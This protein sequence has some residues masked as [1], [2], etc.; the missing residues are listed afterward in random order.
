MKR[1]PHKGWLRSAGCNTNANSSTNMLQPRVSAM[2]R[3]F[4]CACPSSSRCVT[5]LNARRHNKWFSQGGLTMCECQC[6]R[7]ST[8]QYEG[9]L[10]VWRALRGLSTGQLNELG[11]CRCRSFVRSASMPNPDASMHQIGKSMRTMTWSSSRG[12]DAP[13]A[14][15]N[16]LGG[17]LS[18]TMACCQCG[19]L[20]DVPRWNNGAHL[21][22]ARV[23]PSCSVHQSQTLM[24]HR[25]KLLR[26]GYGRMVFFKG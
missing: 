17:P 5:L 6:A 24:R 7:W 3:Q 21:P 23:D 10:L 26:S 22:S 1:Y 8:L 13:C 20:S 14:N 2:C 18:E 16:A 19:V 25:I 11:I 9:L 15:V 4:V 12:E